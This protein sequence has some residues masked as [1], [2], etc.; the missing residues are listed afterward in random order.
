MATNEVELILKQTDKLSIEEMK[1]L[2]QKLSAKF[3][4]KIM[5]KEVSQTENVGVIY[6]KYKNS[7][8]RM[9]TEEDFKLA[10]YHFNED[11]WK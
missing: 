10:E 6:G 3:Y 1:L 7:P 9:S 4:E 8:G 11:E 2:I 5:P